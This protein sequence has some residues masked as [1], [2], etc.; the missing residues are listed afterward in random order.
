MSTIRIVSDGTLTGTK[1][2]DADGNP[3]E[4]ITAV[5]VQAIVGDDETPMA[6]LKVRN[7]PIDF[8]VTEDKV[9]TVNKYV[10]TG[11]E[12]NSDV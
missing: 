2:L 11:D 12:A 5:Y 4:N 6:L 1:V 7:V 10:D 3:I 8:I 9:A